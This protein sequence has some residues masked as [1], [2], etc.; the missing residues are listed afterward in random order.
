MNAARA[1]GVLALTVVAMAGLGWGARAP[2]TPP[3]ADAGL[4]RLSWR[5][6]GERIERC[7]P[8]T[9]SELEAL[10]VHM[11]TPELCEGHLVAYHLSLSVDGSVP[12]TATV[13]PGGARGDRPVFV[14]R[15][16]SLEP[17]EHRVRVELRR[18]D[19]ADGVP[20]TLDTVLTAFAGAVELV[21]LDPATGRLVHR[22]SPRR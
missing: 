5:L 8:R 9:P 22:R 16:R 14:F 21:T 1:A 4:L 17:G 12:D 2:W 3:G 10:P 18:A 6:R 20:L 13:V 7:R 11:R 19:G 15:E